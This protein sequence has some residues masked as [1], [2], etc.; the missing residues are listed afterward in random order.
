MYLNHAVW[1][2]AGC[3]KLQVSF[4]WRATN[5]RAL[6][7]T[8][9]V[10]HSMHLAWASAGCIPVIVVGAHASCRTC[11]WVMSH[12]SES[13]HTFPSLSLEPMHHVA[14]VNESC[15][16]WV[17]HVTHSHHCRWSLCIMSHVWMSHVTYECVMSS[18]I[19]IIVVGAYAS[20]RTCE[21]V[22]SH[23]SESC[24][25]FPSLSLE[26][27]HHVARVNES[28]HVW[29]SHVTHSRHCR[30]SLCIMSHVW[31]SHVTYEWVMSHIPIIVVGAYAYCR[32]CE[33]VMLHVWTSIG[34]PYNI[35][36]L[37]LEKKI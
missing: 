1:A 33:W 8:R 10:R 32:T 6:L 22:M 15:H 7:Q 16:I 17:R 14:R 31:M 5:Y 26:P 30:W 11:E 29:V 37:H 28:C 23:M 4:R 19:P 3:L 35:M 25:T 27:M 9:K 2:S 13:C 21:R 12:M 34:C 36:H 24:H 20:C 18:H